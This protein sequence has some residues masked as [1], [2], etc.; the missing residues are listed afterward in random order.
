MKYTYEIVINC[1]FNKKKFIIKDMFDSNLERNLINEND[2]VEKWKSDLDEYKHLNFVKIYSVFKL[3]KA[4]ENFL[5]LSINVIQYKNIKSNILS[6]NKINEK[7]Q[8]L[9]NLS[10]SSNE[11]EAKIAA[12]K[13]IELMEKYSL[14][15]DSIN[16]SPYIIAL[17]RSTYQVLPDWLILLYEKLSLLSGCSCCYSKQNE[18]MGEHYQYAICK[19]AGLE[20][21]V[22][23]VDYLISIIEKQI[24]DISLEWIA[25]VKKY[26]QIDLRSFQIGL[27]LGVVNKLSKK[28]NS[29][30]EKNDKA[31]IILDEKVKN[32]KDFLNNSISTKINKKFKK[33]KADYKDMGLKTSNQIKLN[34]ATTSN[35]A[36]IK[37]LSN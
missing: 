9:L 10:F 22:L 33:I 30:F 19:I 34:K 16:S 29:F 28:E 1:K 20:R 25:S 17:N 3:H 4:H 14:S 27:V 32:S 8:K 13:A 18:N 5:I 6:N 31:L 2:L 36:D 11:N 7:I 24:N 37:Y 23:N 35:K 15:N 12:K 21:D 26:S